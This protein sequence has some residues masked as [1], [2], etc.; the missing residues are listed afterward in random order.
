MQPYKPHCHC[1]AS[2]GDIIYVGCMNGEILSFDVK[3]PYP[4][5]DNIQEK[6][7]IMSECKLLFEIVEAKQI[8]EICLG[9]NHLVAIGIKGSCYWLGIPINVKKVRPVEVTSKKKGRPKKG[10]KT[11]E[12]VEDE[13]EPIDP[14]DYRIVEELHMAIGTIV[15]AEYRW[16]EKQLLLGS[17]KGFI[18]T[19]KVDA[20]NLQTLIVTKAKPQEAIDRLVEVMW[21][22]HFHDG[23][24]LAMSFIRLVILHLS[25]LDFIC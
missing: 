21:Q 7:L 16:D 20:S 15:S 6:P 22:S 23:P 18:T 3:Q 10:E 13:Y 14:N 1:W 24:I 11:V 4:K 12:M 25:I 17:S 19:I 9:Q 5:F 2:N 8:I